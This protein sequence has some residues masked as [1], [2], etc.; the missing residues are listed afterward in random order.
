VT[1]NSPN[2]SFKG[3]IAI[4]NTSGV[5]FTKWVDQQ[6][7]PETIADPGGLF[8]PAVNVSSVSIN[9]VT[10]TYKVYLFNYGSGTTG[11]WKFCS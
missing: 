5:T 8:D 7:Q 6:D 2:S 4:P 10:E 1:F 11:Q 3:F 9:G